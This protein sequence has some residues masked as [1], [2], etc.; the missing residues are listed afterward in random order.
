MIPESSGTRGDPDEGVE[1]DLVE[2]RQQ[3]LSG[4]VNA[5]MGG[6]AA[7]GGFIGEPMDV[8]EAA[9]GIDVTPL[10]ESRFQAIEPEDAMGDGGLGQ[11]VP[12]ETDGHTGAEGGSHGPAL[13]DFGTDSVKAEG[14]ALGIADLA[15]AESGRGSREAPV[16]AVSVRG[17]RRGERRS[18]EPQE[19]LTRNAGDQ[20]VSGGADVM[21]A[22]GDPAVGQEAHPNGAMAVLEWNSGSGEE[23]DQDFGAATAGVVT[24]ATAG[25]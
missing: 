10:V 8:D 12:G 3:V 20:E 23:F 24:F 25:G 19:L 1:G 4:E 6:G 2:E 17:Q 18:D 9:A 21:S 7:Q 13:T 5:T 11:A 15:D 22:A 16:K 14:G